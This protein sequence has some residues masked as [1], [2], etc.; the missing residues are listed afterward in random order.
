LRGFSRAKPQGK[1]MSGIKPTEAT[2]NRAAIYA[3]FSTDLQNERSIDDQVALC[4]AFAQRNDLE[5]VAIFDDRAVS[6]ASIHQRTGIQKLL[7]AARER[8]FDVI[9]A[10]TMSRI[11]RDEEDRAAIRKRLAFVGISMMTPVDG[12][13]TRLTDGIKAVI[14]SQYLEDLKIMIHRGTAGT[15]VA[16][17][18]DIRRPIREAFSKS[19]RP[20]RK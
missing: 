9:I 12:I 1:T 3:R 10:E 14:D 15:L 5:I 11:G 17:R 16:R 8:R 18:T 6:G 7:V 13:V 4:R 19:I 2:P 20:K